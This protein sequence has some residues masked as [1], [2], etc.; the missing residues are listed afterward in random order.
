VERLKG[1]RYVALIDGEAGAYGVIVPD[2]PGCTS[3]GATLD[4]AI[5][6]AAEAVRLWAED[7]LADGE[8]L[9]EPRSVES[10][11]KDP[12]V[13]RAT[14]EGA[15]LV[16]VPLLIDAGHATKANVSM[17]TWLLKAIDEAA[18]ARGLTR[19]AFLTT[20]AREKIKRGT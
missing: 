13:I 18:K 2:L 6:N 20:A 17:D 4:E 1:T 3:G 12:K 16:I 10:S 11:R 5:Q 8:R 9:P 15:A 19:S 7:A 14:R